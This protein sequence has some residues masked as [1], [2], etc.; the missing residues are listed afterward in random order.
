MAEATGGGFQWVSF[1]QRLRWT[2]GLQAYRD[3]LMGP[4]AQVLDGQSH[5]AIP[6]RSTAAKGRHALAIFRVTSTV[7]HA[8]DVL[9]N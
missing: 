1:F 2:N 8:S 7:H 4:T 3:S 6:R 9:T 5:S